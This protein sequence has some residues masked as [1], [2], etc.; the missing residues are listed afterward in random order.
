MTQILSFDDETF[1]RDSRTVNHF[2]AIEKSMY[3]TVSEEMLNMFSTIVG[4]NNLIGEPVNK[5]RQEYKDLEKLRSLFFENVQ[6]TPDLDKY[7]DFYKWID[8]SLSII[9][10]QLIPASAN[11]SEDVRTMVESHVLER[12]KY[13]HKFPTIGLKASSPGTS[14]DFSSPVKSGA[15]L[16]PE[17]L[18]NY[19]FTQAPIDNNLN[20]QTLYWEY[21]ECHSPCS[22]F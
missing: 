6:N 16:V 11:T 22:V 19:R 5:Y 20:Q 13:Q 4:F 15:D 9:L 2:F 14:F 3:Q 17:A 10:R 12:S 7:V 1:T 8:S 18:P 21:A